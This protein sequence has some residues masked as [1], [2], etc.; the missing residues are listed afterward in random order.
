M[1]TGRSNE[2]GS[3]EP[4]KRADLVI[5]D[6]DPSVHITVLADPARIVAVLKDGQLAA[7]ALP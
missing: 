2:L 3:I 5:V 7:G 1:T 4:G 6:G